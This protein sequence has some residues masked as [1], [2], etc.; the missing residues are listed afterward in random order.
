MSKRVKVFKNIC[1]SFFRRSLWYCSDAI[2]S[3]MA[4]QITNLTIVYWTVYSGADQRKH[5]RFA[6]LTFLL[7][8]HRWPVN[9]P[10]K[11]QK[12]FPFDDVIMRVSHRSP[13][14][15][16]LMFSLKLALTI[17]QTVEILG[18]CDA[19]T[20]VWRHCYQKWLWVGKTNYIM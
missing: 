20:F 5:Q 7:E 2:M 8:I 1:S 19:L 18:I 3:A 11:G 13:L 17:E 14:T 4:S 9:S 15:G 6:S 12:M 10:H 16:A